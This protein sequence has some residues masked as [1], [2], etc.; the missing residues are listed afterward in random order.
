MVKKKTKAGLY[1]CSV[2]TWMA[3][4]KWVLKSI[5]GSE[6]EESSQAKF[7]SLMMMK[8]DDSI[9]RERERGDSGH[10]A[11]SLSRSRFPSVISSNFDRPTS[12]SHV[13]DEVRVESRCVILY[14]MLSLWLWGSRPWKLP[15]NRWT[16]QSPNCVAAA[17][18]CSREMRAGFDFRKIDIAEMDSKL[19]ND[20]GILVMRGPDWPIK[21]INHQPKGVQ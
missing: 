8:L 18:I 14:K 15:A 2:A 7:R 12:Q 19:M 1:R 9:E 16:R 17:T 3:L 6:E 11:K 21:S 10:M 13:G 5:C 4:R 20:K